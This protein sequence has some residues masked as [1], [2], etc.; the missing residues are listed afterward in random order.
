[1]EGYNLVHKCYMHIRLHLFATSQVIATFFIKVVHCHHGMARPRVADRGDGLQIWREAVAD[2]LQGV[3]LQLGGS[4]GAN[5]P[6]PKT[7]CLL[8]STH[9]GLGNGEQCSKEN[10]WAKEE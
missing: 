1:M 7:L 6:H 4:R 10:I 5:N 8:R 9:K 2:S 3:A